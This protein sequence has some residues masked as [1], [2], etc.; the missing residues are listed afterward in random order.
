VFH[1]LV[2]IGQNNRQPRCEFALMLI[3]QLHVQRLMQSSNVTPV[4]A[5]VNQRPKVEVLRAST[6]TVCPK[7]F[8]IGSK[9]GFDIPGRL[10]TAGTAGRTPDGREE[11]STSQQRGGRALHLDRRS[12]L[13]VLLLSFCCCKTL[14]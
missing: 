10:H 8:R 9:T 12:G 14:R 6:H 5:A 3:M 7:P 11:P 4:T 2:N 13:Q 1:Q